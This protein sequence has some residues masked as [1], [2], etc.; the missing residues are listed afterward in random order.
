MNLITRCPA[1]STMFRVV[2]D[3]LRISEGWVRCGHCAEVFDAQAH[4]QDPP[5][6]L[7]VI[8]PPQPP[9]PSEAPVVAQAPVARSRRWR[10]PANQPSADRL[11]QAPIE[12]PSTLQEPEQEVG[13]MDTPVTHPGALEEVVPKESVPGKAAELAQAAR[14]VESSGDHAPE[15]REQEKSVSAAAPAALALNGVD[16]SGQEGADVSLQAVAVEPAPSFLLRA[17][18]EQRARSPWRRVAWGCLSLALLSTLLLQVV[19]SERN[20]LA[21]TQ[22]QSLVLLTP[23]CEVLKCV[24]GPVREISAIRIDSSTFNKIRGDLYRFAFTVSS[25]ADQPLAAPHME[26]TLTDEQ[27]RVLARRVLTTADLPGSPGVVP[28][29]GQW[30]G[31][32]A[33]SVVSAE[34][35]GRVAGYR[36]LAFYP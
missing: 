34:L 25:V 10:G 28:P 12:R 15:E 2:A 23:L 21:V 24:I 20:R 31:Q 13:F 26:L 19:V 30:S 3:Q 29:R 36:L 16:G 17:Q 14:G 5:S 7:S 35:D 22:P 8:T 27:D 6:V 33:V 1:C 4:L 9:A 11:S 18:K 32:W